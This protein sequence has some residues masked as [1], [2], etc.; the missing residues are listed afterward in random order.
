LRS[1]PTPAVLWYPVPDSGGDHPFPHHSDSGS[2]QG[3]K[4]K[5]SNIG[6]KKILNMLMKYEY[7]S[8]KILF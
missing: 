3:R 7:P 6:N 2:L 8:L 5:P 4:T 1:L